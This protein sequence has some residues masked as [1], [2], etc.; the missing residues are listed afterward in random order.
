MTQTA[1]A[2]N[3]PTTLDDLICQP[4]LAVGAFVMERKMLPGITTR[5]ERR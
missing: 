4:F 3:S 2:M 5:A 1:S